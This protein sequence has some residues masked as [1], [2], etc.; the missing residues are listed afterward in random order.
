MAGK[1]RKKELVDT[2]LAANYG[3]WTYAQSAE[4]TSDICVLCYI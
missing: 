3:G 2:R 4:K 1:I